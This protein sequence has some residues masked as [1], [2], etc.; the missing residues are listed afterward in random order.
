MTVKADADSLSVSPSGY[1]GEAV[2][3][4]NPVKEHL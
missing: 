4:P 3:S 2:V 1:E